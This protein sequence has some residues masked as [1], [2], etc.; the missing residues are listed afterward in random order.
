MCRLLD[1]RHQCRS[2]QP[3]QFTGN[4]ST[5]VFT[6]AA[7][8][9]SAAAVVI[10]I[11][12]VYQEGDTYSIS[13]TA[14]TF[15][16]APPTN[17][18]IE[19]LLYR[20]TDIG[21][22]TASAVSITDAGNYYTSSDVE[23]A[24]QETAQS[25]NIV[26]APAGT[27]AVNSTVQ[28]KL[29]E[30]VSV[31]DFGAVGDDV[32]DDTQAFKNAIT[33]CEQNLCKLYV[34]QGTYKITDILYIGKGIPIEGE[35]QSSTINMG[36][37]IKHYTNTTLFYYN[38]DAVSG[39][40]NTGGGISKMLIVKANGYSG[41]NAIIVYNQSNDGDVN[42]RA[43]TFNFSELT[44][45]GTGTGLWQHAILLDG[46][47]YNTAGSRGLRNFSFYK[48]R[49][50]DC[51]ADNEYIL[52]KQVTHLT[53]DMLQID[54]GAGTGAAGIT[55]TGYSQNV[56]LTNSN[57]NGC[58]HIP[59]T[60]SALLDLTFSGHLD[61][62]D[63]QLSTASGGMYLS[64][65]PTV[66]NQSS[67]SLRLYDNSGKG[68]RYL[69][70]GPQSGYSN[71]IISTYSGDTELCRLGTLSNSV[72]SIIPQ[73]N[74]GQVWI[75]ANASSYET[76]G[77]Q[78]AYRFEYPRFRPTTDNYSTL[79]FS[80]NRWSVVYAG[81]G[82][83][84]TS[85]ER[86]KTELVAI[87]DTEILVAKELKQCIKKYRF[88]SS[89]EE[90]GDQARIHFGVGAQTVRQVFE[91]HGLDPSNYS[92]FCYDEWEADEDTP[93]GNRYGIRYDELLAFILAAL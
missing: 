19:V 35:F 41:G 64:S 86:E 23:G 70:A 58:L 79:G 67:T 77:T 68:L 28:T 5:T 60:A 57:I 85:D 31:K 92:L 8:P 73:K 14:L 78:Q 29:R 59:A 52:L 50:S 49:V 7:D 45:T 46:L 75:Y 3:P 6:L 38:S 53:A 13:G 10:Y 51:T 81:T 2:R 12:G 61:E 15:T 56:F 25:Q 24:L 22:T 26:Y 30:S 66:T 1:I 43:S 32:T 54:T 16:E 27:G 63:N 88:L 48:V 40:Q 21:T 9:G 69:K 55:I 17:A 76:S 11:D 62:I 93:A 71:Q 83:I 34:P 39:S 18:S 84:N 44:I 80:S 4:G 42:K 33:Y 82:T 20:V 65:S 47:Q 72:S 87:E 36:T 89:V 90:K 74:D 37:T 91:K